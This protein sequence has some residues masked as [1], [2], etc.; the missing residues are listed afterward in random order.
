[1]F[2]VVWYV[3]F[4]IWYFFDVWLSCD[5]YV[6]VV[7]DDYK[8]WNYDVGYNYYDVLLVGWVVVVFFI[9]FVW[10]LWDKRKGRND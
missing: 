6:S 9:R 8:K 3:F 2:V 7:D 5:V 1:M 4:I 10:F